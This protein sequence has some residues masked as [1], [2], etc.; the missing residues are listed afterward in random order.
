MNICFCGSHG[1]GKSTLVNILK[2]RINDFKII[3]NPRRILTDYIPLG[4]FTANNIIQQTISCG[5]LATELASGEDY[6]SERSLWDTF[7][8]TIA[9]KTMSSDEK[10]SIINTFVNVALQRH[11]V[12]FYTPI[13]FQISGDGFRNTDAEFQREIDNCILNFF[14]TFAVEHK[15]LRGTVE[16]RTEEMFKYLELKGVI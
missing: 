13:E 16:E 1:T 14:H 5:Y 12:L 10:N 6:I 9:S 2:N 11:D 8:Y 15:V 4:N 3:K 7:A